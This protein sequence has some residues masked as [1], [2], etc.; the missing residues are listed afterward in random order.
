MCIFD[1]FIM[2]ILYFLQV[3]VRKRQGHIW[4]SR[5][6]I[7][8]WFHQKFCQNNR[9]GSNWVPIYVW[10]SMVNIKNINFFLL[11]RVPELIRNS[12]R[13][14]S[15][16]WSSILVGLTNVYNW[17]NRIGNLLLSYIQFWKIPEVVPSKHCSFLILFLSSTI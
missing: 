15:N 4:R 5:T 6:T 17:F 14:N 2:S 1:N 8:W 10:F 3:I 11:F 16:E 12:L 13:S 7:S 9:F